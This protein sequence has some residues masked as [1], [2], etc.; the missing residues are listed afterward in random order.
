[1]KILIVDDNPGMRRLLKRVVSGIAETIFECSDGSEAPRSYMDHLPDL[2][3]MDIRMPGMDGIEAT[4]R[5]RQLDANARVVIVTDYDDD[6]LR[7]VAAQAGA[8]GYWLKENARDLPPKL[9][10]ILD[11]LP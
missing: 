10:S 1:M 9:L 11:Q 7:H 6:D 2:V 8:R 5:I 3:L 4:R